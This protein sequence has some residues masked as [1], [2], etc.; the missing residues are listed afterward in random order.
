MTFSLRF[1]AAADGDEWYAAFIEAKIPT[2]HKKVG[3]G[4]ATNKII[5]LLP[6][7]CQQYKSFYRP[8]ICILELD[9]YWVYRI[10]SRPKSF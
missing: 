8:V 9:H 5:W 1:S 2:V 7:F 6:Q 3:D 10:L 4:A